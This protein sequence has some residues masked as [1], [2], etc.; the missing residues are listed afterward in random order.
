MSPRSISALVHKSARS[1]R[2]GLSYSDFRLDI[3]AVCIGFN[4]GNTEVIPFIL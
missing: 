4:G 3:V 2:H 1:L